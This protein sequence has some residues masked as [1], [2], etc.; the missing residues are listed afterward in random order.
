MP[1]D[2][3]G[4]D[5]DTTGTQRSLGCDALEQKIGSALPDLGCSLINCGEGD[6]EKIRVV[7][8]AGPNHG[9]VIGNFESCFGNGPH[10]SNRDWIVV[11]KN[12]VRN[13]FP[14]QQCAHCLVPRVVVVAGID[15]IS[16]IRLKPAFYECDTVAL[17]SSCSN[18]DPRTAQMGYATT[19]LIN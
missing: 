16:G 3:L 15:H 1:H 18:A 17:H 19:T 6:R 11:A 10:G 8:I 13:R 2:K 14:F 4:H 7:N 5:Q 9:N 12:A